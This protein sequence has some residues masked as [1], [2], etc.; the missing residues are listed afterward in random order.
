V[1]IPSF[2]FLNHI[3]IVHLLG[4]V[5]VPSFFG[6]SSWFRTL[7]GVSINRPLAV[8][9]VLRTCALWQNNR[10]IVWFLLL[11]SCV[12]VESSVLRDFLFVHRLAICPQATL[13]V[14][15]VF[16]ARTL[17]NMTCTFCKSP[18]LSHLKLIVLVAPKPSFLRG[19][20]GF[21]DSKMSLYIYIPL[22]IGE[23]SSFF[24]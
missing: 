18:F 14:T 9:I 22:F 12:S 11:I 2:C 1:S 6:Q 15:S 16:T 24:L 17:A 5:S 4:L 7:S 3:V 21:Q 23:L 13:A 10:L 8:I 20:F 19:C